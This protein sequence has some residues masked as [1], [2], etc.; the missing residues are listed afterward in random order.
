MQKSGWFY[1]NLRAYDKHAYRVWKNHTM[2]HD[3]TSNVIDRVNIVYR[4]LY[5]TGYRPASLGM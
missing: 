2:F 3:P 5:L 1:R 4:Q